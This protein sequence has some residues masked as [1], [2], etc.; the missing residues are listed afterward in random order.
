[1]CI[2]YDLCMYTEVPPSLFPRVYEL[3]HVLEFNSSRKRMSVI[4]RNVKN[5]L[6]LLSKGADRLESLYTKYLYN[7]MK[8]HM[9]N[10]RAFGQ[11]NV[12][13]S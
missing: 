13:K 3:L 4:V 1:M 10:L 11:C 5:Q 2:I 9:I 8:L 6:L 12:W 7:H